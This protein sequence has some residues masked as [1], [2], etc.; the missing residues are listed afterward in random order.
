M[1][2]E[3]ISVKFV[4][5]QYAGWINITLAIADKNIEIHASHVYPPF[6]DLFDFLEKILTSNLPAKFSID[7]EGKES[8][9]EA[10]KA[11]NGEDINLNINSDRSGSVN[12]TL[13]KKQLTSEFIREFEEYLD[14][15]YGDGKDWTT[16]GNF[17]SYKND[18]SLDL[19]NIK[20]DKLKKLLLQEN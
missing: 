6:V 1:K 20:T 19:R 11:Q 5:S 12:T 18:P 4:K 17:G 3:T 15:Q 13:N 8:Y 14:T 10:K 7:E 2:S 9:F 16:L